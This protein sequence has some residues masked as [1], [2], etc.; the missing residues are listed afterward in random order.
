M[1]LNSTQLNS[2]QLTQKPFERP[3][4]VTGWC[5]RHQQQQN[6]PGGDQGYLSPPSRRVSKS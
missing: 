6:R 3:L 2:T 1:N 4:K 5:V